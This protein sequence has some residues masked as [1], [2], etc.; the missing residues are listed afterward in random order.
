M[1]KIADDAQR[2]I[3]NL[4]KTIQAGL[5]DLDDEDF[6]KN[7]QEAKHNRDNA[8]SAVKRE[9]DTIRSAANVIT[10]TK[11]DA[12]L[13]VVRSELD[14]SASDKNSKSNQI[15]HQRDCR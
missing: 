5:A 4:F 3:D 1:Q 9:E 11:I 14:P 10:P 2:G 8:R 6:K 12:F 7:F 15:S 13:A